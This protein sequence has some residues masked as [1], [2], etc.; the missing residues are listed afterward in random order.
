LG[1]RSSCSVLRLVVPSSDLMPAG[2]R[3]CG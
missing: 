3:A 2:T 1:L